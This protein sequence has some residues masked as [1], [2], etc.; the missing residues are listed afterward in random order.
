MPPRIKPS[1]ALHNEGT[2]TMSDDYCVYDQAAGG[3]RK[4]LW[5]AV[6]QTQHRCERCGDQRSH[7]LANTRDANLGPLVQC[8]LCS[9][10]RQR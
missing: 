3:Y 5:R 7:Q 4:H 8:V 1:P 2:R 10:H 9:W 6:D